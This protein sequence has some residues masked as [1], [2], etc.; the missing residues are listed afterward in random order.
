VLSPL[1]AEC[2][3]AVLCLSAVNPAACCLAVLCLSAVNPAA[4][5][6]AVLCLS[7]VNPAAC[8]LAVLCCQ[9]SHPGSMNG[10]NGPPASAVRPKSWW[11]WLYEAAI[12]TLLVVFAILY[13]AVYILNKSVAC[14]T[15][16]KAVVFGWAV[17]CVI[18][19]V[20]A[21]FAYASRSFWRLYGPIYLL[22]ATVYFIV[23]LILTNVWVFTSRTCQDTSKGVT[24]PSLYSTAFYSA[25]FFDC[26]FVLLWVLTCVVNSVL[27]RRHR[28]EIR[29]NPDLSTVD[30]A[31]RTCP[32]FVEF[33]SNHRPP[34]LIPG[35]RA[36]Y[37]R[38]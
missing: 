10:V 26:L 4:C 25:I 27:S 13:F 18:F 22:L 29:S 30:Y 16:L 12:L 1:G 8:C 32:N 31:T 15:P 2:Y 3:L 6:L 28:E 36:D 21:S 7:A 33:I 23:W 34:T 38:L 20:A 35:V 19:L 37:A 9:S 5:C 17:V 11:A 14:D 24:T